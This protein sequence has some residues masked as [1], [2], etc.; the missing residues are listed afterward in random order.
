M[1]ALGILAIIAAAFINP[2]A[3]NHRLAR[4]LEPGEEPAA[5]AHDEGRPSGFRTLLTCRPLLIFICAIA[6]WQLGNAAMLPIIGQKLALNNTGEGT[7]FMS[8]LIVVAQAVMVPMSLLVGHRADRWGRKPIFLAG[9]AAL[10]IR[11][12]LFSLASSPYHVI[13]IQVLDGIGAG[14][15]GA[16]FPLIVADLTRGTGRYNVTLAPRPRCRA[17]VPHSARPSPGSSS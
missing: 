15:F 17:S 14:I 7:L 12:V 1:S 6:L 9:F 16:L 10:P 11:G 3:I 5:D 4:G 2:R 8:A 13:P